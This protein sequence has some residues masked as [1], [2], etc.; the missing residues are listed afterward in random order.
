M[1]IGSQRSV[2]SGFRVPSRG[3]RAQAMK[4]ARAER[5]RKSVVVAGTGLGL[6]LGLAALPRLAQAAAPAAQAAPSSA[7]SKASRGMASDAPRSAASDASRE[8][9][10]PPSGQVLYDR[11]CASCHGTSGKGDGPVAAALAKPPSDLTTLARRSGG[12]LDEAELIA[13]ID[14]RRMVA[15]HGPREMPVWGAVFDEELSGQPWAQYTG[16]LRAQVLAD[17]LRSL[18]AR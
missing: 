16:L 7:T 18:Q 6:V 1:A 4:S 17:H 8:T 2:R 11:Y 12:R 15:A 5:W 3:A 14:G 13:V 9:P 10:A